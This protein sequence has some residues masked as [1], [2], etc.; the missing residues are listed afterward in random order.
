M[1]TKTTTTAPLTLAQLAERWGCS[2]EKAWE[3]VQLHR[4]PVVWFGKAAYNPKKRGPKE[5]L[6][7]LVDVERA[8]AD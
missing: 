2:T 8:E 1:S 3:R 6:F 7:R 5:A 4:V